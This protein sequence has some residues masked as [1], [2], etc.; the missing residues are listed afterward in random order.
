MFVTAVQPEP[1]AKRTVPEF[2]CRVPFVDEVWFVNVS[3]PGASKRS[4]AAFVKRTCTT[5]LF[6]ASVAI[7]SVAGVELSTVV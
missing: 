2:T 1:R 3:D 7:S 4:P 6:A 5:S